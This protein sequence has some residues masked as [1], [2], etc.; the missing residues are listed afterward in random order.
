LP[1]RLRIDAVQGK[2]EQNIKSDAAAGP[3]RTTI[4]QIVEGFQKQKTVELRIRVTDPNGILIED[5]R[6]PIKF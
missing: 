4:V 5:R 1:N 6:I 3:A 2:V